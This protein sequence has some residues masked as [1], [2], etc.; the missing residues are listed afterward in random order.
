MR[1]T[2]RQLGVPIGIV[3]LHA[4][5]LISAGVLIPLAGYESIKQTVRE[6]HQRRC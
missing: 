4:S 6:E 1:Y 3:E 5:E 2:V